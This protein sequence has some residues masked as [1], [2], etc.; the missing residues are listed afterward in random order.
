MIL[1]IRFVNTTNENNPKMLALCNLEI[2]ADNEND[3]VK[4]Y[5]K[6][7]PEVQKNNYCENASLLLQKATAMVISGNPDMIL[8]SVNDNPKKCSNTHILDVE[9]IRRNP[10]NTYTS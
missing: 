10:N 9:L 6:V 1:T 3:I 8:I 7:I 2:K 4:T 5:Q